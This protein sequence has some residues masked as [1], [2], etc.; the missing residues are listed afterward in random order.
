MFGTSL[1]FVREARVLSQTVVC[2]VVFLTL[3][4]PSR[5]DTIRW[6]T[7][8][9]AALKEAA[10]KGAPLLV[11]VGTVDC[12]W[13]KQLDLRTFLDEDV[14]RLLT[15]RVVPIKLDASVP[16]NAYLVQALRV[17]SYP[18]L[19]FASYDGAILSYKEGFLEAPAL[20]EQL[21]KLLVA[22]GTPEW[23]Q[24]DFDSAS[25]SI[26]DGEQAKAISLLKGVVADGKNRPVQVRARKQLEEMEK[27][28]AERAADA[29]KL[30]DAGKTSEAMQALTQLDRTYPGTVAARQGKELMGTLAS[31]ESGAK[32]DRKRQA[33]ELLRQAREDYK[34]QHYLCALDRCDE[35]AARYAELPEASE[36]EKLATE[37][38]DNPEWSQKAAEQLGERLCQLYFSLADTWLKKGQPQQAIHYLERIPRMF[39]G[40]KHAEVAQTRLAR[41]RGTPSVENK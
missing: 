2:A 30:A 16:G 37:I 29:R 5:A 40:T 8:Y 24:R 33:S 19:V 14:I 22:V 32:D 27:Q 7:D 28:A 36:A 17:Q 34:L 6:R 38:K 21:G 1:S 26:T 12:Y 11:N 23:M 41:L 20:K 39:P 13:C 35:L 15:E 9:A 25:K 4:S 31:R 3:P 18:T 10:Q